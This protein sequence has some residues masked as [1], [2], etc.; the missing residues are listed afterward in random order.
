MTGRDFSHAHTSALLS[1][2]GSRLLPSKT[3]A[4]APLERGSYVIDICS[5]RKAYAVGVTKTHCKVRF[6]NNSAWKVMENTLATDVTILPLKRFRKWTEDYY[7]EPGSP[8]ELQVLR[9]PRD[10]S[11]PLGLA[12]NAA[13]QALHLPPPPESRRFMSVQSQRLWQDEGYES[14]DESSLFHSVCSSKKREAK[15]LTDGEALVDSFKRVAAARFGGSLVAAWQL[16]LDSRN[17]GKISFQELVRGGRALGFVGNYRVLWKELTRGSAT[18]I[19]IGSLDQKAAQ[20]LGEFRDLVEGRDLTLEELWEEHLD[21][22]GSGQCPMHD[23]VRQARSLGFKGSHAKALFRMLDFSNNGELSFDELELVG[24]RRQVV[25]AQERLN[26]RDLAKQRDREARSQAKSDFLSRLI[27][28]FGTLVRAWRVGLDVKKQ[29]KVHF[30]DFCAFCKRIGFHGNLKLLWFALTRTESSSKK[31]ELMELRHIDSK[32]A[33]DLEDFRS[34]LEERFRNMDD[35]WEIFDRDHSG[36]CTLQEFTMGCKEMDFNQEA[37][38]RIFKHL[39]TSDHRDDLTV[40]EFEFIGMSRRMDRVDV[41]AKAQQRLQ[42]EKADADATVGRFRAFLTLRYG[43]LF[44]AWRTMLDPDHNGLV[45]YN[46]FFAACRKLDFRGNLKALWVSL[47]VEGCGEITMEDLDPEGALLYEDFSRLLSVFFASL[48][49][50]WVTSFDIQEKGYCTLEEFQIACKSLRFRGS[51]TQ[52]FKRLDFHSK[53][54]VTIE[55]FETVVDLKRATIPEDARRL[56]QETPERTRQSFEAVLVRNFGSLVRGWRRGL[57]SGPPQRHWREVVNAEVFGQRS[58]LYGFA[59]NVLTLWALLTAFCDS[60][61]GED[62]AN[63]PRRT[64]VRIGSAGGIFRP[65]VLEEFGAP[66]RAVHRVESDQAETH[67]DQAGHHSTGHQETTLAPPEETARDVSTPRSASS[68][69][70]ARSSGPRSPRATTR[71]QEVNSKKSTRS[72][73]TWDVR[74][75]GGE[76]QVKALGTL[77]FDQLLPEIHHDLLVFCCFFEAQFPTLE[78]FWKEMLGVCN[79]GPEGHLRLTEFVAGTKALGFAGNAELVFEACDLN[80]NHL[81]ALNDMTFLLGHA[82]SWREGRESAFGCLLSYPS[83]VPLPSLSL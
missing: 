68:K 46:E 77:T 81:L 18:E 53:G 79:K 16:V 43:S 45:T 12:C 41:K 75:D 50:A 5:G 60:G 62:D 73:T 2:A 47:D 17:T 20:L 57:C 35:A 27:S 48:D 64:Y 31:A 23:F 36:R 56:V 70:A 49:I 67:R 11:Q 33:E 9:S 80:D 21:P 1:H 8:R 82:D 51:A 34:F 54:R 10:T 74:R 6:E 59:G 37:A 76:S 38:V 26:H 24:I 55:H 22:D 42:K 13:P 78:S 7:P 32:A 39:G 29:G 14:W 63:S 71:P 30:R 66:R 52:L 44:Q 83:D 69:T 4:E 61:R 58:H 25:E 40:D 15:Q 72:T 3:E 19:T 65:S 28:S